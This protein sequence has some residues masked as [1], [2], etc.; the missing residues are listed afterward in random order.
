[1]RRHQPKTNLISTLKS[2]RVPAGIKFT[3]SIAY[4]AYVDIFYGRLLFHQGRFIFVSKN[5][6]LVFAINHFPTIFGGHL[7]FV[8]KMQKCI[9][10]ENGAR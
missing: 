5:I 7:E 4:D 3:V 2:G 10:L 9:Y 1:M 6:L 8:L